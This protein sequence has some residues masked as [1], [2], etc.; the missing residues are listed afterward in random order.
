MSYQSVELARLELGSV[1]LISIK[2]LSLVHEGLT[3]MHWPWLKLF[4]TFL[5]R[6][7]SMRTRNLSQLPTIQVL[8][9]AAASISFLYRVNIIICHY[10]NEVEVTSYCD[11]HKYAFHDPYLFYLFLNAVLSTLCNTCVVYFQQS[12]QLS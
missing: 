1:I 4:E 8:F 12:D 2:N 3:F 11:N 7:S 6:K 10:C 5:P 9:G